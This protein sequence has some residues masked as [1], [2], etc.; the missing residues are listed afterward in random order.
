MRQLRSRQDGSH[1]KMYF[2][3]IFQRSLALAFLSVINIVGTA[4]GFVIPTVFV[5]T[6]TGHSDKAEGQIRDQFWMLLLFE[7]CLAFVAALLNLFFFA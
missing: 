7:F 1:L 4:V 6:A 3:I 2:L 5:D